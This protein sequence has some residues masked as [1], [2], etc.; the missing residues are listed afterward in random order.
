MNGIQALLQELP[1]PLRQTLYTLITILG[2]TLGILQSIDVNNLGPLTM[3]QALQIYAFLSPLVG[4]VAVANVNKP[5]PTD[6]AGLGELVQDN[7]LDMSAFEPVGDIDD[8]YGAAA[9]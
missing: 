6:S 5:V 2:L 4:A 1:A 3:T 9:Q 7:D 8:V